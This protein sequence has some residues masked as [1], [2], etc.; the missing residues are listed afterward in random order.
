MSMKSK[1]ARLKAKLAELGIK[2]GERHTHP[3]QTQ[4][5]VFSTKNMDYFMFTFVG[6][7]EKM[8]QMC[9]KDAFPIGTAYNDTDLLTAPFK[10]FDQGFFVATLK[11]DV[12]K[13]EILYNGDLGIE[14]ATKYITTNFQQIV[15]NGERLISCYCS[16]DYAQKHYKFLRDNFAFHIIGFSTPEQCEVLAE[17]VV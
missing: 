5:P 2:E 6:E 15:R 1:G 12:A 4:K 13:H 14:Q 9:L 10:E 3:P 17:N 16:W 11:G 7:Y 8:E